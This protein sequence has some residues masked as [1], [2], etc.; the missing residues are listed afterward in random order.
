MSDYNLTISEAAVLALRIL[1]KPSAILDIYASVIE[2]DLYEFGAQNPK[3]V[4]YVEILRRCQGVEISKPNI[5]KK[6]YKTSEELFGLLEWIENSL[7]NL[8]SYEKSFAEIAVNQLEV[9]AVEVP[10]IFPAVKYL[11][12]LYTDYSREKY[13]LIYKDFKTSILVHY[14]GNELLRLLTSDLESGIVIIN[15]NK[16]CNVSTLRIDSYINDFG[17]AQQTPGKDD[18]RDIPKIIPNKEYYVIFNK[19]QF[20][21]KYNIIFKNR[22]NSVL[23]SENADKN[24]FFMTTNDFSKSTMMLSNEN[25]GFIVYKVL[26][27]EYEDASTHDIHIQ[28]VSADTNTSGLLNEGLSY[29]NTEFKD[30]KDYHSFDLLRS[31]IEHEDVKK[32]QKIDIFVLDPN[33]IKI[34]DI[35]KVEPEKSYTIKVG[36]SAYKVLYKDDKIAILLKNN[37]LVL[38]LSSAQFY[39]IEFTDSKDDIQIYESKNKQNIEQIDSHDKMVAENSLDMVFDQ[40][41]DEDFISDIAHD[42]FNNL[43]ELMS[44]YK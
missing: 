43:D 20:N 16:K 19:V 39:G 38:T 18:F 23:I 6:F 27:N 12:T 13:I 29:L 30:D 31:D 25:V 28:E 40:N 14:T 3:S 10:Y 2:N 26:E 35:T 36:G 15:G 9:S 34:N 32:N 44:D 7:N 5:E 17:L 33:D 37:S 8:H 22:Y 4:L 41:K 11:V 21:E 1:E 24:L 42:L